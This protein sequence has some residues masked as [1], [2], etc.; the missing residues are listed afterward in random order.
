MALMAGVAAFLLGGCAGNTWKDYYTPTGAPATLQA[1]GQAGGT[2]VRVEHKTM[3]EL[4]KFVQAPG[5]RVL[6]ESRFESQYYPGT[7][8]LIAFAG[9]LGATKV[10]LAN[11][12]SRT[13]FTQGYTSMPRDVSSRGVATVTNNDGTRSRV[14]VDSTTTVWD[15]IPYSRTDDLYRYLAVYIGPQEP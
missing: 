9:T 11:E 15:S 13:Q 7:D 6:G 1:A 3:A 5:E 12:F 8:K 10:Y 14:V 2:P 4:E